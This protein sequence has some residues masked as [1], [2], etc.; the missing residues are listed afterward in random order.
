VLS[1]QKRDVKVPTVSNT[2]GLGPAGVLIA[3]FLRSGL[4]AYDLA[5]CSARVAKSS[6]CGRLQSRDSGT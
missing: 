5:A 1:H 2:M 6:H 4:C 3:C